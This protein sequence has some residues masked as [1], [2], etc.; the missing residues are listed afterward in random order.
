MKTFFPASLAI[1][2]LFCVS[3]YSQSGRVKQRPVVLEVVP[4]VASAPIQPAPPNKVESPASLMTAQFEMADGTMSDL[5]AYKGKPLVVNLWA[6]WCGPCRAEIPLLQD[7]FETYRKKGLEVLGVNYGD[8]NGDVESFSR[9]EG[10]ARQ[11]NMTYSLAR[12]SRQFVSEMYRLSRNF[13]VPQT[14]V[15]DREGN[16]RGIYVGAPNYVHLRETVKKV[17]AEK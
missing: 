3:S 4:V 11:M 6:I 8:H 16:V 10:F 14:I 1:V 15:I 9:I 17:V 7:I 2:L 5:T 12:G 13:G